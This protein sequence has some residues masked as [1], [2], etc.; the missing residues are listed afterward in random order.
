MIIVVWKTR[1][2]ALFDD[3]GLFTRSLASLDQKSIIT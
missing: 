3:L 2:E 1:M